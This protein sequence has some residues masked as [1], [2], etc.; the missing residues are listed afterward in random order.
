MI[1]LAVLKRVCEEFEPRGVESFPNSDDIRIG[2]P[3]STRNTVRVVPILQRELC[4]IDFSINP[5]KTVGFASEGM[6][7]RR[8]RLHFW[9]ASVFA[10]RK[11]WGKDG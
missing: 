8:K 3:E 4:E 7:P 11:G 5:S 6:R 2:M 10:L 1:L 9:G